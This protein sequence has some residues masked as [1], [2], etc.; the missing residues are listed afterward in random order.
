M[1]QRFP[2]ASL[3][4]PHLPKPVDHARVYRRF[5][6]ISLGRRP[7]PP[8]RVQPLKAWDD[9]L[10]T[11]ELVER[12]S[13]RALLAAELTFDGEAAPGT[14][15]KTA[16]LDDSALD[17]FPTTGRFGF[18]DALDDL[19]VRV[20]CLD[21]AT[22]KIAG[23]GGLMSLEDV[24][25]P[26]AYFETECVQTRTLVDRPRGGI[27]IPVGPG[28]ALAL[29]RTAP[30]MPTLQNSSKTVVVSPSSGRRPQVDGFA[31]HNGEGADVPAL[32]ATFDGEERRFKIRVITVGFDVDDMLPTE[33][34]VMLEH[35]I[36]FN[37][38][39]TG[40]A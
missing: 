13:R 10:V 28:V 39:E 22:G 33:V 36:D 17:V 27:D 11:V 7:P 8:R 26:S 19:A 40:D 14:T 18:D 3:Q 6:R 37:D 30:V 16:P 29:K 23:L 9:F 38:F 20:L 15:L 4:L 24:D 25:P 35:L 21:K 32:D 2:A 1:K 12:H 31:P 34:L 5:A